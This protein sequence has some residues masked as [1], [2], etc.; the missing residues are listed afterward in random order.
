MIMLKDVPDFWV[1]A[2]NPA[3]LLKKIDTTMDPDHPS[4]QRTEG[5]YGAEKDKVE[6]ADELQVKQ[7]EYNDGDQGW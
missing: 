4:N 7:G 6:L 5:E 3:R 2:G 1:A